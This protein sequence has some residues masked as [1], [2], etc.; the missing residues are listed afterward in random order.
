MESFPTT[1]LNWMHSDFCVGFLKTFHHSSVILCQFW[2]LE[3][4]QHAG[5]WRPI[6]LEAFALI[7][8]PL[9][10]YLARLCLLFGVGCV[11]GHLNQDGIAYVIS[12]EWVS[13]Q[14]CRFLKAEIATLLLS[15]VLNF[16]FWLKWISLSLSQANCSFCPESGL[17]S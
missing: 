1:G 12:L 15:S 17:L 16:V 6:F 5:T 13:K 11:L 9:I 10:P 14:G 8:S 7:N 4:E 3:V 2:R